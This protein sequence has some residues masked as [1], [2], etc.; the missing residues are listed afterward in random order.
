M[1]HENEGIL[2]KVSFSLVKD[3]AFKSG[4]I[5]EKVNWNKISLETTYKGPW[6]KLSKLLYSLLD[7]VQREVHLSIRKAFFFGGVGEEEGR[8]CKNT[9]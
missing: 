1:L 5:Q 4:T 3:S 9:G 6:G 8:E 2:S 7:A